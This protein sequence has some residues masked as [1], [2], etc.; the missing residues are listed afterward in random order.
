MFE[1]AAVTIGLALAG[2]ASQDLRPGV[3]PITLDRTGI[4]WAESFDAAMTRAKTEGEK[5]LLFI[6]ADND[7]PTENGAL[8]VET[9]RAG[10][11]CDE[12]IAGLIA[13]RFVPF[14]LNTFTL[15]AAY[16][17]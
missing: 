12:R 14:Y 3:N 7:S 6:V 9:F 11:L 15:T 13:R 10:P 8:G 1:I 5:R 2:D 16:D 17:A 4:E